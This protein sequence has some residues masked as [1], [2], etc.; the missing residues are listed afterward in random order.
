MRLV[1]QIVSIAV[2]LICV[3]HCVGCSHFV[4]LK[5]ACDDQ[6]SDTKIIITN[7]FWA[8]EHESGRYRGYIH[9]TEQPT[10][11]YV[12]ADIN[13]LF[14]TPLPFAGR[15]I[16]TIGDMS[17]YQYGDRRSFTF[18]P[19]KGDE[20]N[21]LDTL[22]RMTKLYGRFVPCDTNGVKIATNAFIIATFDVCDGVEYFG[23]PP[24]GC[25][26]EEGFYVS[27]AEMID[28]EDEVLV[29][30]DMPHTSYKSV[31]NEFKLE[32]VS[33]SG[34]K[35]VI[36]HYYSGKLKVA[37]FDSQ[38]NGYLYN[39]GSIWSEEEYLE[40]VGFLDELSLSFD[41]ESI[42]S[43]TGDDGFAEAFP[44]SFIQT[45]R[46]CL[47]NDQKRYSRVMGCCKKYV[48]L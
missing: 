15:K 1:E 17:P 4:G 6:E 47:E 38:R 14:L 37:Y 12:R 27:G 21:F 3:L 44:Y 41:D 46:I 20:L 43:R 48:G 9:W 13:D 23:I 32:I 33:S 34:R 22:D 42:L 24:R 7:S 5:Q 10:N 31:V 16:L 11:G 45:K 26:Q 36:I 25:P 18:V 8:W 35:E 2:A 29:V 40:T 28:K 30:V 39:R 19:T